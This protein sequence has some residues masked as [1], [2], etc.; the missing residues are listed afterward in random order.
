MDIPAC[1]PHVNERRCIL[2]QLLPTRERS[3]PDDD[4]VHP[5][6][7]YRYQHIYKQIC[8]GSCGNEELARRFLCVLKKTL[9]HYGEEPIR[10]TKQA[11]DQLSQVVSGDLSVVNWNEE[12]RRI[13]K[14]AEHLN[15]KKRPIGLACRASKSQLGSIRHGQPQG[16][17]RFAT[18]ERY[19]IEVYFA[20]FAART[21][22]ERHHVLILP[23]ASP[24][25]SGAGDR[26]SHAVQNRPCA[27][28]TI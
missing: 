9:Q 28:L 18:V 14:L 8:E 7:G 17:V 1:E 12:S 2:F 4:K 15:G 10:L 3:M 6:L 24:G 25:I 20:D 23:I 5:R 22:L 19:V 13:D 26:R 21:P 27:T 16:D 11:A